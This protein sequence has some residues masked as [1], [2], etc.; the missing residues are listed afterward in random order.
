M[1]LT[2][3]LHS[4]AAH[5]HQNIQINNASYSRRTRLCSISSYVLI[6]VIN[7]VPDTWKIYYHQPSPLKA[8]NEKKTLKI[9]K[10]ISINHVQKFTMNRTSEKVKNIIKKSTA[11]ST[12]QESIMHLTYTLQMHTC[13]IKMQAQ[14]Y[15]LPI[16]TLSTIHQSITDD[17]NSLFV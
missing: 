15:S 7:N 6:I 9:N 17:V 3:H 11:F 12:I 8:T 1:F 2:E 5:K 10:T 14:V 4:P 13:Y 16:Y